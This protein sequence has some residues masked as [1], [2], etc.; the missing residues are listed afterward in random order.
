MRDFFIRALEALIGLFVI[1]LLLGVV[2]GGIGVMVTG[3]P[4]PDGRT[5]SGVVP[6]IGILVVGVLYVVMIAGFMYLGLG[7]YHN[8]KRTAD[9][10]EQMAAK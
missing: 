7:I 10:V 8:T 1:L 6:G 5:I 3:M 2:V 9:A 4:Q